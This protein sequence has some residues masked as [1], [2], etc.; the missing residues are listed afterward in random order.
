MKINAKQFRE[1]KEIDSWD[2][3]YPDPDLDLSKEYI[4]YL[5]RKCDRITFVIIDKKTQKF[6]G[7]FV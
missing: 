6:L 2:F 1:G 3:E 5:F 7:D 4:N